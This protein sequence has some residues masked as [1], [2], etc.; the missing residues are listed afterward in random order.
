MPDENGV[1]DPAR[2]V[3]ADAFKLKLEGVCFRFRRAAPRGLVGR[4]RCHV[5]DWI[6]YERKTRVFHQETLKLFLQHLSNRTHAL[7]F[8]YGSDQS[9]LASDTLHVKEHI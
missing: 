8:G 3:Y 6:I 2:A 9:L 7:I 5:L 4:Y 1:R